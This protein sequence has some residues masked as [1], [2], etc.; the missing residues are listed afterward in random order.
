MGRLI[1]AGTSV[2]YYRLG[3]IPAE[4]VHGKIRRGT[5]TAASHLVVPEDWQLDRTRPELDTS[6]RKRKRAV[7]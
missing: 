5:A 4:T 6:G 2:E 1:P 3:R 7:V